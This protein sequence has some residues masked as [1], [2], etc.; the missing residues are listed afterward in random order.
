[1]LRISARQ[2]CGTVLT[3]GDTQLI[4]LTPFFSINLLGNGNNNNYYYNHNRNNAFL[5]LVDKLS[6]LFRIYKFAALYEATM[7]TML[8]Y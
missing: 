5:Y 6:D 1:M 8:M 7:H 2:Y 4:V 3:A